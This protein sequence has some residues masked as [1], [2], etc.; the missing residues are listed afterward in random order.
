MHYLPPPHTIVHTPNMT[1]PENDNIHYMLGVNKQHSVQN[2]TLIDTN[3]R[4]AF[5]LQM[6]KVEQIRLQW[7]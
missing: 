1:H 4:R 6:D 2:F 3:H 7:K 5:I